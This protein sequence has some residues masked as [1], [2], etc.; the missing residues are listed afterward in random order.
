[1]KK[2]CLSLCLLF[3]A[4]AAAAQTSIPSSLLYNFPQ[5][6][7]TGAV[8]SG[9]QFGS[10]SQRP[11]NYTIDVSVTGTAPSACTFRVEGSN[12][13]TTWYGL[14]TTSP[15]T[16]SCTTA[17][18]EHIVSKPVLYLRINVVAYTAGDGTTKVIF[19]YTGKQ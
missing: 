8:G 13:N 2:W 4:V 9:L 3:I 5:V 19:H 15:A 6:T 10:A 1:M 12:D 16:T 11:A 14:D 7:T 18:M 17:F